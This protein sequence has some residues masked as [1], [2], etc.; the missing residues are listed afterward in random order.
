MVE[1]R[2]N[3]RENSCSRRFSATL[4]MG[5]VCLFMVVL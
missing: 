2:Q 3:R 5:V 4:W 1:N